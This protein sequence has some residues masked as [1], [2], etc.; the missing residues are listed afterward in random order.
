MKIR[1]QIFGLLGRNISYSLSPLIF[2]AIFLRKGLHY[3][4]TI[5]DMEARHLQKF[6]KGAKL[7]GIGGFNV[8]I[9]YKERIMTFVDGTDKSAKDI[10]AIN[11]IK[12]DEGKLKGFN[13]D[14]YGI[15]QTLES[16]MNVQLKGAQVAVIGAGG[17]ARA[18]MFYLRYTQSGKIFLLNRST[19]HAKTL[20]ELNKAYLDVE[21]IPLSLL[22]ELVRENDIFIIIN[23]TPVPTHSLFGNQTAP[24]GLRI[25]DLSYKPD[26][27]PYGR[28]RKRCDGR[29]M[30]AAQASRSLEL[31]CGVKESTKAIYKLIGRF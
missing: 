24:K 2:N 27:Y 15:Q 25:F 10:G 6:I 5:F 7:L 23:S 29:F 14:V 26:N 20:A 28:S 16:Y 31:L 18:V 3:N 22:P 13:T 30:L 19:S 9:P 21:A 1:P 8:T 17:A 12:I 4:Y 11:L